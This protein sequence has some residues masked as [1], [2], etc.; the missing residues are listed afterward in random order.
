MT[1]PYISGRIVKVAFEDNRLM[2]NT[3]VKKKERGQHWQFGWEGE[4]CSFNRAP[5]DALTKLGSESRLSDILSQI[6]STNLSK[7]IFTLTLPL[8]DVSKNSRPSWSDSCFPRSVDTTLS[9]SMSHLFPTRTTWAL[10]QEQ[11][12]ICVTL[13]RRM[14]A[15]QGCIIK[16]LVFENRIRR[17]QSVKNQSVHW[18]NAVDKIALKLHRKYFRKKLRRV[19]LRRV[20]LTVFNVQK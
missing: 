17:V 14:E 19:Q 8:A 18:D 11:V 6:M 12:L 5:F 4:V 1:N 16:Q 20:Q 15:Q 9:S 10:S 2:R 3:D 7:T 13:D